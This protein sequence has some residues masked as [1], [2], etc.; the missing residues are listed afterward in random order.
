[1]RYDLAVNTSTEIL[2]LPFTALYSVL[3]MST[4]E[5]GSL[6]LVASNLAGYTAWRLNGKGASAQFT[7]V[8]AGTGVVLDAPVMGEDHLYLPVARALDSVQD[9]IS[10]GTFVAGN[11]CTTL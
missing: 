9:E 10:S 3:F 4:L 8:M 11:P 1:V 5:D 7:G 6:V 2:R